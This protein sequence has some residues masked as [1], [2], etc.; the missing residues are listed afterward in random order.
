M[1]AIALAFWDAV[2]S[3]CLALVVGACIAYL[4][5]P[6]FL[7][8][9]TISTTAM[10]IVWAIAIVASAASFFKSLSDSKGYSH[11]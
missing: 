1:M 3:L 4:T 2:L 10:A 8:I 5:A 6:S 7:G 9:T 11:V